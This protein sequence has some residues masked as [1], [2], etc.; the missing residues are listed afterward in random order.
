[1]GREKPTRSLVP[2]LRFDLFARMSLDSVSGNQSTDGDESTAAFP[3]V[4][5]PNS[6]R[7][8]GSS[9]VST[10]QGGHESK[11]RLVQTARIC[12]APQQRP[13][14]RPAQPSAPNTQ[15]QQ[16]FRARHVAYSNARPSNYPDEDRDAAATSNTEKKQAITARCF[17]VLRGLQGQ[18]RD[19]ATEATLL[20]VLSVLQDAVYSVE[21]DTAESDE[22]G[23][24]DSDG[25]AAR[26]S[27]SAYFSRLEGAQEVLQRLD[28]QV[29]VMRTKV[30]MEESI[31][32]EFEERL[33]ELDDDVDL[34][35]QSHASSSERIDAELA[36]VAQ[37]EREYSMLLTHEQSCKREC[38]ALQAQAEKHEAQLEDVR[39]RASYLEY[40]S[41]APMKKHL[42]EKKRHDQDDVLLQV[43]RQAE[44]ENMKLEAEL[45]KLDA[46]LAAIDQQHERDFDRK[47]ALESAL[48]ES[49]E[50]HEHYEAAYRRTR[51]CHTPRPQWDDIVDQ[52]P[53]LS[54]QK[55]QWEITAD[56]DSDSDERRDFA[57]L[58][59]DDGQASS[60]R[61]DRVKG[62]GR[63]KKLV[64]EMLHWI[65][66]LQK[67]IGVNLHLSRVRL[68]HMSIARW[69]S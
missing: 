33:R 17:E 25:T 51:E 10:D 37:L 42:D 64:K 45:A 59:D 56:I 48:L 60:N 16:R 7:V 12:F 24:S 9:T 21:C 26:H 1:M 66:R 49:E 23:G 62:S 4:R 31:R 28:T 58:S 29:A 2:R 50:Q 6:A 36:V 3:S 35:T 34:I 27:G 11:P 69:S 53:E 54:H 39:A 32:S 8:A 41:R 22:H 38:E 55:F 13:I 30:T 5:A 68:V 47:A 67:H 14:S 43:A 15:P 52:T 18:C 65:E 63:T 20:H 19:G 40:V 46:Q 44:E 57:M 61:E